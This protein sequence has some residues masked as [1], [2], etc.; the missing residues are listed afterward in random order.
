LPNIKAHKM[1]CLTDLEKRISDFQTNAQNDLQKKQDEL[2]NPII[3]KAKNA[4][5]E[6]AKENGYTYILD[7]SVGGVVLYTVSND[8]ILPL[9]KKKLGIQ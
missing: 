5:N 1:E 9:V 3:E 4:I 8:D 7:S 6:V 2:L